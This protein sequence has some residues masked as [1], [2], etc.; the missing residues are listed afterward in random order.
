MS[1][2]EIQEFAKTT[3]TVVKRFL[4]EGVNFG[5]WAHNVQN[6]NPNGESCR[7][8]GID[9][10]GWFKFC[11]QN[12]SS[13]YF[14]NRFLEIKDPAARN[15]AIT[16]FIKTR[17]AFADENYFDL[18]GFKRNPIYNDQHWDNEVYGYKF[19]LKTTYLH[20]KY[21]TIEKVEED[22]VG[23]IKYTYAKSSTRQIGSKRGEIGFLNNRFFI[24]SH[25]LKK[26]ENKYLVECG[27]RG[28]YDVF[29]SLVKE[30]SDSNVF[31]VEAFN[32]SDYKYYL[33]DSV[34]LIIYEDEN[35]N[36]SHKLL[37]NS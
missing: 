3:Y 31:K 2:E 35:G 33:V 36:V 26:K 13:D 28:R 6:E 16:R 22:P 9:S 18:L 8:L 27:F 34:V 19:D 32:N 20:G 21:D 10:N 37:M 14:Y 17:V 15:Y 24:I 5:N 11:S 30:F 23:F 7:V 25:S 1:R 29:D 4:N 12:K